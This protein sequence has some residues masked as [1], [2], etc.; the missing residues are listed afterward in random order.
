MSDRLDRVLELAR[1]LLEI[2]SVVGDERRIADECQGFLERLRPAVLERR[3]NSL[4][5]AVRPIDPARRTVMLLGHLDTV[6]GGDANPVRIEGDRL[7]G[8]GASDMKA[9][10]AVILDVLAAHRERE[11][12]HN[13]IGVL[14]AQEEGPFSRNELPLLMEGCRDRFESVDLAV[15]MEPTDGCIELGCLGTLHARV[16][17]RGKRAHSARPWQGDNAIHRTAG[18]LDRLARRPPR[19]YDFEGLVFV[20]SM[21]ATLIEGGVAPNVVPDLCTVNVNF[22]F[23]PGKD[24]E[25]CR[26]ELE[27]VVGG[28]AG[29]VIHDFCPSGRVVRDNALLD[30]LR[31]AAGNPEVRAK[32]AWTDVGR[33]SQ[34]GIDAVNFGPG[35]TSQAHRKGEWVSIAAVGHC[36]ET[37]SDWLDL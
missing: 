25:A 31:R 35:A 13:V 12:R 32:Q 23:A 21:S 10:C 17:F 18:L 11:A 27:A 29:F 33:L 1:W 4:L 7:Y 9:A 22:R 16:V 5:A 3:A 15:A 37:M 28:E 14:Y 2:D 20:E 8:L 30:D 36:R 24:E 26:R 6:P 19:N 34:A